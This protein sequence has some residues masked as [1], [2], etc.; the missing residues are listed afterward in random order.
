MPFYFFSFFSIS[1]Q[2][3]FE[4]ILSSNRTSFLRDVYKMHVYGHPCRDLTK[5]ITNLDSHGTDPDLLHLQ[6]GQSTVSTRPAVKLPIS[7]GPSSTSSTPHRRPLRRQLLGLD[8]SAMTS[9]TTPQAK[10]YF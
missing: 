9:S 1:F 2:S 10:C 4:Y 6:S 7:S 3:N 8:S 5:H